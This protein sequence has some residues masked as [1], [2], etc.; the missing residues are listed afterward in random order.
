MGVLSGLI[1]IEVFRTI[2]SMPSFLGKY[3][4]YDGILAFLNKIWNLR[5]MPSEDSQI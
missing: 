4:E 2:L 5:D 3:E 1:K